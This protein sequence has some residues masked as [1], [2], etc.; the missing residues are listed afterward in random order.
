MT[1][2]A[3]YLCMNL[4]RSDPRYLPASWNGRSQQMSAWS[5]QQTVGRSFHC[6]YGPDLLQDSKAHL[7]PDQ[8]S[9]LGAAGC[10]LQRTR[11]KLVVVRS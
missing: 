9:Y 1:A 10:Q 6:H 11:L 7:S 3:L 4:L 5:M 2:V 8:R